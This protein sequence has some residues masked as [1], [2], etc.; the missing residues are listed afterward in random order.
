MR[1]E[2]K[3]A[4]ITGAAS[5]IGKAAAD[6]FV[7]EG[8]RV[9]YSDIYDAPNDL[10]IDAEKAIYV[11]CDV[12]KRAEVAALIQKT[13]EKFSALDIM[14]NNAGVGTV[15]S[16]LEASD[17]V[18]DKTIGVNLSGTFYGVQLA[19]QV[20]KEKG[21][22]G[23]IIN[24]S[25]ILGTVGLPGTVAYCASKG[26]IVQL[27]HAAALDLAAH[28]I[29][30]NAIA[31]GFIMTNMT[32]GMLNNDSFSKLVK[33]N[34]PLGYVGVPDDIAYAALY[35]ASDESKYV[36]GTILHVDGGWTAR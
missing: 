35:L 7:A 24:L 11:K 18:W 31:P 32:K 10:T 36:T 15:G 29:R 20:M 13:L 34:T 3:V 17:E 14:V 2:N 12:S 23:S 22:K 4:I 26:G 1:L 6:L 19:A 8:A 28:G 27:T 33:G 21:I 9:V 30:I 16:I 5:G 25:S